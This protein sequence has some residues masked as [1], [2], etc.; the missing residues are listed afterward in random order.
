MDGI[1]AL[2]WVHV[3]DCT[4]HI[5]MPVP[6]MVVTIPIKV[7]QPL[8]IFDVVDV[9]DAEEALPPEETKPLVKTSVPPPPPLI[10]VKKKARGFLS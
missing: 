1:D 8:Y 5:H 6:G 2:S 10:P 9:I 7:E 4:E 3:L